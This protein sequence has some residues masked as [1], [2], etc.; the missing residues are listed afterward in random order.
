MPHCPN[1]YKLEFFMEQ[2][3]NKLSVSSDGM[4]ENIANTEELRTPL[5]P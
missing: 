1:K 4:N 3:Q 5:E 2:R